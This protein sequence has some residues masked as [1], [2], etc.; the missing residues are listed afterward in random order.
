[1]IVWCLACCGCD[2]QPPRNFA[3]DPVPSTR[4]AERPTEPEAIQLV[5]RYCWLIALNPDKEEEF[6]ELHKK[7][8]RPVKEAIHQSGIRNYSVYVCTTSDQFYAIRYY[9]YA[10]EE[11]EGDVAALARD[12]DFKAWRNACEECEVT[13]LPLRSGK[14]WSPGNEVLHLD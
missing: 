14:W 1:M 4:P 2:D 11:H 12:P 13:L 6:R 7:I 5:Q 3:A 8:P 10:G 9:E